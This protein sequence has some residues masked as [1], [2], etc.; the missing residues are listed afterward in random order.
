[1]LFNP[2][3]LWYVVK[4]AQAKTPTRGQQTFA[5]P[6]WKILT[7]FTQN[8]RVKCQGMP[9]SHPPTHPLKDNAAA[10]LLALLALNFLNKDPRAWGEQGRHVSE[11][12]TQWRIQK[13]HLGEP[14]ALVT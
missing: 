5:L 10:S 4:A 13:T 1:M 8:A 11:G 6:I 9:K 2:L 14:Q 3:A 12:S 7:C